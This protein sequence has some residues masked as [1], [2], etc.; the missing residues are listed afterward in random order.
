[1]SKALHDFA[2]CKAKNK[3]KSRIYYQKVENYQEAV[4]KII[5]KN[6]HKSIKIL[7]RNNDLYYKKLSL[8]SFV[9]SL[10]SD[11]LNL[12]FST[13]H[14]SKGLE[15]DIVILLEIDAEKFP[16]NDKT[17]GLYEI[18]GDT[19]DVLFA[20]EARLFYV[21]LTRAKEKLYI[22]SKNPG[23]RKET[24][25]YNFFSYLNPDYLDPLD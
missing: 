12:S 11:N 14:K 9:K 2:G 3:T 19:S 13:I 16:S 24:K 18:F 23:I 15:A 8:E 7:S 21:A 22:L 6:S 4:Q 17:N 10:E 20:D 5:T 25:K 1:M